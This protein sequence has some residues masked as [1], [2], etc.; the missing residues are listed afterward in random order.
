ME[1]AFEVNLCE[2]AVSTKLSH[3]AGGIVNGTVVK[4]IVLFVD[5][6]IN[7]EHVGSRE[8]HDHPPGVVLF[9]HYAN[10]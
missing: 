5:T 6:I 8:V 2:K 9:W 10:A 4:G 1:C 7:A 3:Q